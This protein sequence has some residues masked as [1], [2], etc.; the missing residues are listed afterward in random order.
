MSPYELGKKLRLIKHYEAG[1]EA[2]TYEAES[3]SGQAAENVRSYARHLQ[4]LAECLNLDCW[5]TNCC[6][7]ISARSSGRE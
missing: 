5:K 7:S 3:Y 6:S 4:T 2:W 1:A